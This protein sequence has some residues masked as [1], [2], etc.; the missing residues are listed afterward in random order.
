MRLEHAEL[1][2]LAREMVKQ[3]DE[4]DRPLPYTVLVV[5]LRYPTVWR[6][7]VTQAPRFDDPPMEF[8]EM[9]DCGRVSTPAQIALIDHDGQV[10]LS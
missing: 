7:R 10:S 2:R 6:A 1:E 9:R 4:M 3:A 5:C 8:V